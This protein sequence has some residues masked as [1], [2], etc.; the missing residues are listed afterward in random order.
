MEI[1]R[2]GGVVISLGYQQIRNLLQYKRQMSMALRENEAKVLS[3]YS[4][5]YIYLSQISIEREE[6]I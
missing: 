3:L 4:I 6:A 2:I 5:I 1:Q